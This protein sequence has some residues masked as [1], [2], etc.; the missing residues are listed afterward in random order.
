MESLVSETAWGRRLVA[1]TVI[2]SAA[3]ALFAAGRDAVMRGTPDAGPVALLVFPFFGLN[4]RPAL[5]KLSSMPE[6]MVISLLSVLILLLVSFVAAM[7][8]PGRRGALAGAAL[9]I[10]LAVRTDWRVVIWPADS[11][12]QVASFA[13][14]VDGSVW[15]SPSRVLFSALIILWGCGL[16]HLLRRALR[17]RAQRQGAERPKEVAG[18]SGA[19]ILLALLMLLVLEVAFMVARDVSLPCTPDVGL[20]SFPFFGLARG[21]P[22]MGEVTWRCACPV[23]VVSLACLVVL[24]LLLGLFARRRRDLLAGVSFLAVL[25]LRDNVSLYIEWAT[26]APMSVAR[27][28]LSSCATIALLSLGCSAPAL[29]RSGVRSR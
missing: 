4:Y 28:L 14:V 21:S 16:G 26:L 17:R 10:V 19:A 23:F 24:G 6:F 25:V 2:V 13:G 1:V 18:R 5:S 3:E 11:E 8:L 15:L 7:I 22:E 20:L 12:W 9:L 27:A 29:M